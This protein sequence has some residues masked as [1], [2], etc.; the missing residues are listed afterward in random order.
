MTR[1]SKG[2]DRYKVLVVEKNGKLNE[3]IEVSALWSIILNFVM[4]LAK[5]TIASL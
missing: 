1:M 5:S 4:V 2:I 3:T